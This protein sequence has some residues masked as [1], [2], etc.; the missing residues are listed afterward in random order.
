[1]NYNRLVKSV[2][3]KEKELNQWAKANDLGEIQIRV[4][5]YDFK[6]GAEHIVS[7]ICWKDDNITRAVF[8]KPLENAHLIKE[9]SAIISR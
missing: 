5:L 8:G 9:D 3:E 4:E 6:H 7:V 2:K 1:M